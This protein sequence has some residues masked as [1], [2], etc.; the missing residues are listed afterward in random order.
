MGV[1]DWLDGAWDTGKKMVGETVDGAAHVTG[2][3]LDFVGLH[4]AAKSVD[5]WGD[6]AADSLGVD[7]PEKQLGETDDPKELVHGDPAG[8]RLSAGH[9]RHFYGA[10]ESTGSGLLRLDHDHWQGDAADAFRAKFTPHAKQWLTAADACQ[11]AAD[12]LEAYAH[13]VEWAQGQAEQCLDKYTRAREDYERAEAAYNQQVAAY[14]AQ[15]DWYNVVVAAGGDPGAVPT[16]PGKFDGD[17]YAAEMDLARMDLRRAREQRD[18]AAR[19]AAQAVEAATNTAPKEPS[20]ASRLLA[21]GEDVGA[22]YVLGLTHVAGGLVKGVADLGRFARGLNPM[23]PYNI[24]HPAVWLDQVSTT[25]AGILH[26]SNHPTELVSALV[27]SGWSSDPA[28]AFGKFIANVGAGVLT[29]GASAEASVAER[30]AVGVAENAAKGEAENMAEQGAAKSGGA[31][32]DG[33]TIE[34]EEAGHNWDHLAQ[35]TDHVSAKA[36]HHD[37]TDLET[38]R[39]FLDDQYPWLKDVN[40]NG[41]W[42]NV[43]GYNQNC[44]KNVEA[45]DGRLDGHD[46]VAEPLHQPAWPSKEKLGNPDAEWQNGTSYDSIIEDM[47]NRGVGSRGVVYISRADGTAHVFNVI[48]DANGVVFLDGQ[49]G[50]LGNLEKDVTEVRYLPYK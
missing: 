14:N 16:K 21:D 29:D 8:I 18:S 26:A 46:S 17:Q 22:G 38:Q 31:L 20:F 30:E 23:D 44:S 13:A 35:S 9:L 2:A 50:M 15:A 27:G 1:G 40:G 6:S 36:I 37:V 3:G 47:D 12:A 49:T 42:D 10:F 11:K 28:E 19:T 24:T 45:I 43:P 7:I 32:P 25:A 4:D 39:K 41:Y 34:P 5:D 48:H 33:W